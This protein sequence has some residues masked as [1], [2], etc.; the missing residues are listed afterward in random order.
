[1]VRAEAPA[2]SRAVSS[3][4]AFMTVARM[5][6]MSPVTRGIALLGHLHAAEDV[7]ATDDDAD[8]NA[9]RPRRRQIGGDAVE[10]RLMNPEAAGPI[11]ASPETLTTT[12]W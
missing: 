5:P 9:E 6:I 4:S 10:C 11:R 7:A 8:L 3:A 12:R 1:M 2:P